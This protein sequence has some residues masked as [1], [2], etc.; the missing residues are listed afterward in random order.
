MTTTGPGTPA[1]RPAETRD[2]ILKAAELLFAEYGVYAV[3]NRQ[4]AEAA[5]QRNTSAVGY[6][7]GTKQ[8]LVAAIFEKHNDAIERY[9]VELLKET[10]GSSDIREWVGC[11]VR[12]YIHHLE[13]Q[14]VETSYARFSAQVMTEPSLRQALSTIALS[15][16]TLRATLRGLRECVSELPETV[17]R[18]RAD[19]ARHLMVHMSAER[20]RTSPGP[21]RDE[22]NEWRAFADDLIDAI[23]GLWNASV[24]SAR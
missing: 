9:R 21:D 6:H 8:D 24:S 2:R 22:A 12:P 17:Q 10:D 7:F 20:E 1:V 18:S 19:M 3:S 15:S 14:G 4:V 16:P 13:M 11:L 5:G 23:V